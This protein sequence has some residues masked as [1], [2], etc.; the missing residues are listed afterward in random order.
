MSGDPY[1]HVPVWPKEGTPTGIEQDPEDAGISPRVDQ[2]V[3]EKDR[4]PLI[5]GGETFLAYKSFEDSADAADLLGELVSS[6]Y[7][8]EFADEGAARAAA[9]GNPLVTSKLAELLP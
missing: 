9:G 2:G 1:L 5:F 3:E 7:V 4:R 6:G 8:D